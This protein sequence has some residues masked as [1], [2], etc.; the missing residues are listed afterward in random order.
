MR[1]GWRNHGVGTRFAARLGFMDLA[2]WFWE[3]AD[4]E[5]NAYFAAPETAPGE[6]LH[7]PNPLYHLTNLPEMV[8]GPLL[9]LLVLGAGLAIWRGGRS[10]RLVLATFLFSAA[11]ITT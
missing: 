7:E 9:V 1:N 6:L 5:R 3:Y 4:G 2:K 11:V 8:V 10:L